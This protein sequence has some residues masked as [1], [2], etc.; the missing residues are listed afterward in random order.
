MKN[1]IK[2]SD[3]FKKY[4]KRYKKKQ[5]SLTS[6]LKKLEQI[7]LDNPKHGTNLGGNLYKIKLAVKS[8][9]KGKSGRYRIITYLVTEKS[10]CT[11]INLVIIYDKT[12]ISNITKKE[13]IDIIKKIY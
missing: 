13:L 7:L 9:N 3:I 2:Y 5:R 4:F 1:I 11:E 6:D 8:K 10:N 12:D